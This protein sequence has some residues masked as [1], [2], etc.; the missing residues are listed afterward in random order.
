MTCPKS[1]FPKQLHTEKNRHPPPRPTKTN[2]VLNPHKPD[3]SGSVYHGGQ[4]QYRSAIVPRK[5]KGPIH[6]IT[7]IC[8]ID[9]PPT[10]QR[11]RIGQRPQK[12]PP[13]EK[14]CDVNIRR[15]AIFCLLSFVPS[16][17]SSITLQGANAGWVTHSLGGGRK[18]LIQF[19]TGPNL[20]SGK[21][22]IL[23]AVIRFQGISGSTFGRC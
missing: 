12:S 18:T 6:T 3:L 13:P 20:V 23:R 16:S 9:L 7:Q 19:T 2:K 4:I 22:F 1:N 21:C 8:H 5:K 17:I 10:Q 11:R 14:T 15:S